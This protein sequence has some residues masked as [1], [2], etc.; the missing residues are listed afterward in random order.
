MR[1]AGAGAL[2]PPARQ[3][4]GARTA[5]GAGRPRGC[6]LRLR[7]AGLPPPPR[8]VVRGPTALSSWTGGSTAVG[9]CRPTN[10]GRLAA[11]R[12]PLSGHG[13]GVRWLCCSAVHETANRGRSDVWGTVRSCDK[14]GHLRYDSQS[15]HEF[16]QL[17]QQP[18]FRRWGRAEVSSGCTVWATGGRCERT[19]TRGRAT[20]PPPRLRPPALLRASP[21]PSLPQPWHPPRSHLP[22]GR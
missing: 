1:R 12:R 15:F 18:L 17:W 2:A 10:G 22:P 5:A 8:G 20:L 6:R 14:V 9:G 19:A 21:V 16:Y 4:P 7:R 11:W 13:F 3:R